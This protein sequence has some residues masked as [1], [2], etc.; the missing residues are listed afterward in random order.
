[1]ENGK[2]RI[3]PSLRKKRGEGC[4]DGYG[5]GDGDGHSLVSHQ[6]IRNV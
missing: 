5:E 6:Q 1:V 4:G 3:T 2:C